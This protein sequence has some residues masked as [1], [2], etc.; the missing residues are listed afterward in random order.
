MD[1]KEEGEEEAEEEEEEEFIQKEEVCISCGSWRGKHK[2]L[3]EGGGGWWEFFTSGDWR[4]K[5]NV[6]LLADAWLG[7]GEEATRPP[8][9][10]ENATAHADSGIDDQNKKRTKSHGS[11]NKTTQRTSQSQH[12]SQQQSTTTSDF[13]KQSLPTTAHARFKRALERAQK[14]QKSPPSIQESNPKTT[15]QMSS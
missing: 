10:L 1:K 8:Y 4:G 7:S 15:Q 5:H 2:S 12:T 6:E 3:E 13:N 9:P 11:F 14:P